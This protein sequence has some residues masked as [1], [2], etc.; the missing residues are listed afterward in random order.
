MSHFTHTTTAGDGARIA[1]RF[2]GDAG[3]PVLLLS[4]SIGT[5]LSMWDGE[6]EALGRHFHVLR[7]DTRGHGGS[8]VTPG[9]YSMDR[10]GR[11]AIELLDALKIERAHFLGLSLGGF[12]GQWLGVHAPERIDRLVLANT[13]SWLGPAR[14][15]D[16]RIVGVLAAPDMKETAEG[17]LRNWFPE[18]L[19]T[20]NGPVV[21]AFRQVLLEIDPAGPGRRARRRARRRPAPAHRADR[22]AHAGDRGRVRPGHGREPWRTDRGH[23]AGRPAADLAR[24][25]P[26]ERG[27]SEGVRGRGGRFPRGPLKRTGGAR[28]IDCFLPVNAAVPFA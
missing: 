8:G 13:S 17:F 28:A 20:E 22:A 4:N 2:D 25:A 19:L 21:Q 16:E 12:I 9:A 5:T 7:Y 27:V 11:D 6:V 1:Y 3:K 26:V 14:V 24:G 18:R 15:F 10:L 23:R